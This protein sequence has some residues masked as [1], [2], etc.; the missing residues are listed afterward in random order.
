MNK[1]EFIGHYKSTYKILL[2][3]DGVLADFVSRA[4]EAHK[5]PSPYGFP[6]NLGVFDLE[7]CKG[8]EMT[9]EE[10][11][12]PVNAGGYE[13]WRYLDLM[14]EAHQIVDLA[15]NLVGES[16]IC[17]LSSPSQDPGCVPGKRD[18]MKA[19]FPSLT[20]N[21]LFGSAKRF[22]AGP[23]KILLDDRDENL[24]SFQ[25]FGGRVVAVPRPWNHLHNQS[26]CSFE[27]IEYTLRNIIPA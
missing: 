26:H 23:D 8:W 3:M 9:P 5:K 16:N 21:M 2:D 1:P 10:F 15:V 13:F 4:C 19:H 18:W 12:K 20:K 14:P 17:I 6:E 7:K 27:Y 22:V 25:E 24:K 11:W